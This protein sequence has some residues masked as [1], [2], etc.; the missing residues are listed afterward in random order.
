MDAGNTVYTASYTEADANVTIPSVQVDV[1]G[2]KDV[3]GNPQVAASLA[4][5]F[6]INTQ[7]VIVVTNNA[8]VTASEGSPAANSGTYNNP[9]GNLVSISASAGIISRSGTSSGALEL[10]VHAG[11]WS[12]TRR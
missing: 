7:G 3:V 5:A 12:L 10:V 11:R 4:N 6:A 2:G 8:T 1:T 9:A